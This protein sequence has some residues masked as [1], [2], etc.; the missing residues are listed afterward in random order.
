MTPLQSAFINVINLSIAASFLMQAV[1][2]LRP[3]LKRVPKWLTCVLWGMVALRLVIPFSLESRWSLVPAWKVSV[4]YAEETQTVKNGIQQGGFVTEDWQGETITKSMPED[5][6]AERVGTVSTEKGLENPSEANDW[7]GLSRE[8]VGEGIPHAEGTMANG[9]AAKQND[10]WHAA[11]SETKEHGSENASSNETAAVTEWQTEEP[12]EVTPAKA[13][14]DE[15]IISAGEDIIATDEGIALTGE[16]I[17]RKMFQGELLIIGSGIWL[18]GIIAMLAYVVVSFVRLRVRLR[19]AVRLEE[20]ADVKVWMSDAITEPFVLG[21]IRPSIY[22]PSAI[23]EGDLKCVLCHEQAH[24][25]RGDYLWK[26]LGFLILCVYWFHPLCWISYFLFCRD[27]E[28]ACDEKATKGFGMEERK[29]YCQALL[30]LGQGKKNSLIGTVAFG[31]NGTKSRVKAVLDYKKPSFRVILAGVLACLS[32]GIFFMT[33]QGGYAAGLDTAEKT[34]EAEDGDS[35]SEESSL[36]AEEDLEENLSSANEDD[37]KL[38][39]I[40]F[41]GDGKADEVQVQVV[42][43][44]GQYFDEVIVHLGNRETYS[45]RYSGRTDGAMDFLTVSTGRI[46][47]KEKT[48]IVL[49]ITDGKGNYGSSDIH[50]IELAETPNGKELK[51][52]LTILDGGK[53]SR[54]YEKYRDTMLSAELIN[55][56]ISMTGQS[57][58]V[59]LMPT[60]ERDAVCVTVM[61]SYYDGENSTLA[62]QAYVYYDQGEWKTTWDFGVGRKIGVGVTGWNFGLGDL[63]GNGIYEYVACRYSY[64]STLQNILK[65]CWNGECIYELRKD[66]IDVLS[67]R[68][69]DFDGDGVQELFLSLWNGD[70]KD[71]ENVYMVLKKTNIGEWK[72][73]EERHA[74]PESENSF[75]IQVTY[76]KNQ[77]IAEITLKGFRS[78]CDF[79][80]EDYC[81]G[82]EKRIA[83]NECTVD[84]KRTLQKYLAEYKEILQTPWE[85]LAGKECGSVNRWGLKEVVPDYYDG[86]PCL[87]ATYG[88]IGMDEQ[89]DWGRIKLWFRYDKD[90]KT[91]VLLMLFDSI[92]SLPVGE[93]GWGYQELVLYSDREYKNYIGAT[94]REA[95]AEIAKTYYD[96]LLEVR[97]G[98]K[99]SDEVLDELGDTY[100]NTWFLDA[101]RNEFETPVYSL[102]D[103]N[104]DGTEEFLIGCKH[105]PYLVFN[106]V[107]TWKDGE[108]YLLTEQHV[109]YRGGSRVVC[110][111][112]AIR[113]WTAWIGSEGTN[114][115]F[116]RLPMN[117]TAMVVEEWLTGTILRSG[118]NEKEV[119]YRK[120][121][122]ADQIISKEEYEAILSGELGGYK[123]IMPD[124]TILTPDSIETLRTGKVQNVQT[125]SMGNTIPDRSEVL[126]AYYELIHLAEGVIYDPQ[127]W[128]D[129]HKLYQDSEGKD[130][131]SWELSH[132]FDGIANDHAIAW[133]NVGYL[134]KDID[135]D[136]VDELLFGENDPDPKGSFNGVIYDMYT[137]R[138]HQL[139]HLLSGWTKNEYYLTENGM[140][141]HEIIST[142]SEGYWEFLRYDGY[143]LEFVEKVEMVLQNDNKRIYSHTTPN[144]TEEITEKAQKAIRDKYVYVH[145]DFS[146][147]GPWWSKVED[148]NE[149]GLKDYLISFYRDGVCRH[150][151]LYLMR[152]GIVYD[153][154]E[155]V[156]VGFGDRYFVDLDG[157]GEKEI[158]LMIEPHVNSMPLE[159]FAVL[160]KAG[161]GWKELETCKSLPLKLTHG[162]DPYEIILGCDGY[163][164]TISFSVKDRYDEWK[165]LAEQTG[166]SFCEE[167]KRYYEYEV[168]K[169]K[170]GAEIG[171]IMDWG[172]W[173]IHLTELEGR[174]CLM[175]LQGIEGYS[176]EDVWGE[177]EIC[178]DYDAN[179]KIRILDLK[180]RDGSSFSMAGWEY[181]LDRNGIPEIPRLVTFDEGMDQRFELWE[182]GKMIWSEEGYSVH[183]G[184]NA[185]FLCV[186]NGDAYLLRYHPTMYQGAGTYSYQLFFLENGTEKVVQ[187]NSVKFD[188]NFH[189]GKPLYGEFNPETIAAFMDEI[190]DLLSHSTQLLN[191]DGELLETFAGKTVAPQDT[192]GWLDMFDRD[193]SKSLLENLQAFQ[194]VQQGENIAQ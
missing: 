167:M 3:F 155:D 19:T 46:T 176:K 42:Q 120:L 126:N 61:N 68:Y 108:A 104:G 192:L 184:Y 128:G 149:D 70:A 8:N 65:V 13:R 21:I 170:A 160:K 26:P 28:M 118:E 119:Y 76:K 113:D 188:T 57:E 124:T 23:E 96:A 83:S 34:P 35:A 101:A 62:V 60:A 182:D 75:P 146:A 129:N 106:D 165:T 193:S 95:Y 130:L 12:S 94:A 186:L 25:K 148:L 18:A 166:D 194:L 15:S 71:V 145:P 81:K 154:E 141:A 84:E 24:V 74:Y 52:I 97:K 181:D 85:E 143:G 20:G 9:G 30:N 109:G 88:I 5:H 55:T 135:G 33:S 162:T 156:G 40:D 49:Q 93:G 107:Y 22:V 179:G 79:S 174:P 151:S 150:L 69:S 164:Q 43:E 27:V 86:L 11:T 132:L 125:L 152:Q 89:D 59:R 16:G 4:P 48:D 78:Y 98:E 185:L 45:L 50:V 66:I 134:I 180:L 136:G 32:L 72:A 37:Q 92:M 115:R 178:F 183:A 41:D 54:D 114:A 173:E 90:G 140:I 110:E 189:K 99:V 191:T 117:G 138:D 175:A 44:D 159:E 36:G 51:E 91:Q 153:H 39:L 7:Q 56:T 172:I 47:K 163:E 103:L 121:P 168:A 122:H 77:G 102:I 137:Y 80:L 190:N 73:L 2:L 147:M 29:R 63:D 38:A 111:N 53:N 67:W 158:L 58:L 171:G 144:G 127:A 112:G 139:V 157:D 161:D 142:A 1:I 105:D 17:L 87:V 131:F 64:S 82:M 177:V 10:Q 31:E 6:D 100:V 123:V 187:E 14:K 116:W 169:T 133:Q